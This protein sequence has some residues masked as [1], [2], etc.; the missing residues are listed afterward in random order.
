MD[1]FRTLYLTAGNPKWADAR[2]RRAEIEATYRETGQ[3]FKEVGA[4][5]GIGGYR[6][7]QL[8]YSARG[9]YLNQ[10]RQFVRNE[11]MQPMSL[12]IKASYLRDV[13][14]LFVRAGH[15]R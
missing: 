5:F 8:V 15:G 1:K 6:A 10:A 12:D 13:L 4:A 14:T 3:S 7:S 9:E 11:Q 2:Q